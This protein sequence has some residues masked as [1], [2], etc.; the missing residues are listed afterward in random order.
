MSRG[1][2]GEGR[3]VESKEH[4]D[5]VRL[6]LPLTAPQTRAK[7]SQKHCGEA[8]R[9][10]PRG[11]LCR[12][13]G[14]VRE[15]FCHFQ[16]AVLVVRIQRR[17]IHPEDLECKGADRL[18]VAT[19]YE[20]ECHNRKKRTIGQFSNRHPRPVDALEQNGAE[21]L[22]FAQILD[23]R[24]LDCDKLS[25]LRAGRNARG[26]TDNRSVVT[27]T[28]DNPT[29]SG[30]SDAKVAHAHVAQNSSEE[31]IKGQTKP[32]RRSRNLG[33]E[34]SDL[35]G[36]DFGARERGQISRVQSVRVHE[37]RKFGRALKSDPCHKHE[38]V[39]GYALSFGSRVAEVGTYVSVPILPGLLLT[40][41][42]AVRH[43]LAPAAG[44]KYSASRRSAAAERT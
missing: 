5:V 34:S 9:V 41:S 10:L 23:L 7:M 30:A 27:L 16:H 37:R 2:D 3:R 33:V 25:D 36:P 11:R 26:G 22:I 43:R 19:L 8:R 12:P 17:N 14:N 35:T 32:F 28:L 21:S 24:V 20:V 31:R 42:G 39:Y 6:Y 38:G 13:L 44:L 4:T 18:G 40:L 15:V 1:R 29:T